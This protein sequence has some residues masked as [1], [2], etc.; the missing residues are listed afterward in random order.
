MPSAH[1]VGLHRPSSW[2]SP[3]LCSLGWYLPPCSWFL[4]LLAHPGR[5]LLSRYPCRSLPCVV[6]TPCSL[7]SRAL[8]PVLCFCTLKMKWIEREG[9][10][11]ALAAA[12]SAEA[13]QQQGNVGAP[14]S[15]HDATFAE[16]VHD[17]MKCGVCLDSLEDPRS[18]NCGHTFCKGCLE[19][20]NGMKGASI[21]PDCRAP[22]QR[23]D[24]RKVY[25]IAKLAVQISDDMQ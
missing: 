8:F 5:A 24:M 10:K 14:P 25:C 19:T 20:I 6:L 22:F 23:R 13:P 9:A 2:F 4:P 21:C 11:E 18:I 16:A 3:L 17:H 1:W 12:L 15:N 7:L